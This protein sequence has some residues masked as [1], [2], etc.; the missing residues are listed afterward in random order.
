MTISETVLVASSIVRGSAKGA[1]HGAIYLLDVA[2]ERVA[3]VLDWKAGGV[4][5]AVPGGGR[6]LR[7]IAFD[8][9]RV[10]VAAADALFAFTPDFEMLGVYRSPY[11]SKCHEINSFERRLYIVSK[12]FDAI[13]GFNLDEN[14]FDRGLH[15]KQTSSGLQ[16]SPFDP[17]TAI[18][19]GPG[20]SL[21][22]NSLWCDGRGMFLSGAATLGLLLFDARRMER[23]LTLPSGVQNARPWRDGV[24]FND[25]QARV[26]R[27]LTPKSNQVFRAPHYP[28]SSAAEQAGFVRGLCV[29]DDSVFAAG[30]SPSTITLHNLDTMKTIKS[31]AL[32]TDPRHSIHSLAVWPYAVP[33]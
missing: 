22:L 23:V 3:H 11:L 18:G 19:P 15:I 30:S 16:G 21:G 13:V 29:V 6:G 31:I 9:Q 24:L 14:R 4:D 1:S 27:F 17:Q 8:G 7:G 2:A 26:T 5:W 20:G 12:G 33:D 10:F 28:A 32:S 25:A